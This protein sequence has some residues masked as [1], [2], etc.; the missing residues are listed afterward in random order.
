M[1]KKN[2]PHVKNK[3]NYCRLQICGIRLSHIFISGRTGGGEELQTAKGTL[4]TNLEFTCKK[5]TPKNI[6][7]VK[8]PELD[9]L[10]GI[11]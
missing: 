10:T 3:R 6:L 7:F 4:D 9:V 5:K 1:W 2:R 8:G 11:C